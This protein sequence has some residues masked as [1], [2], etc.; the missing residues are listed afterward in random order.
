M[1][2]LA[3]GTERGIF[4]SLVR[5]DSVVRRAEGRSSSWGWNAPPRARGGRLGSVPAVVGGAQ[6]PSMPHSSWLWLVQD[7]WRE[8][9]AQCSC[10]AEKGDGGKRAS[11]AQLSAQAPFEFRADVGDRHPSHNQKL[12]TQHLA[13]PV[14][15]GQLA[16]DA[17]ILAF[18]IPAKP[19]VRNGV[20]AD[21]LEAAQD[22]VLFRDLEHLAQNLNFN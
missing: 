8:K 15:V 16:I 9:V 7:H 10:L 22:R 5:W 2:M 18:L 1:V 11:P 12:T 20:R 4:W 19:S 3:S 13:R 17:A 21:E 14:V 6:T